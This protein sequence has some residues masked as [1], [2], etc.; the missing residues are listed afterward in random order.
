MAADAGGAEAP[1][2]GVPGGQGTKLQLPVRLELPGRC[3][4]EDGV[5]GLQLLDSVPSSV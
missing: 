4:G 5:A 2:W 1:C 3:L